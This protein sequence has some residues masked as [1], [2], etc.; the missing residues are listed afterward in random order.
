MSEENTPQL[1]EY[2]ARAMRLALGEI[3]KAH[4]AMDE[5][6]LSGRPEDMGEETWRT[7]HRELSRHQSEALTASAA[8][9]DQWDALTNKQAADATVLPESVLRPTPPSHSSPEELVRALEDYMSA[10][11]QM[12]AAM[13]DGVNVHGAL[14]NLIG[15]EDNARAALSNYRKC[16]SC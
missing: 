3:V 8:A 6:L 5:F 13:K 15:A 2:V 1:S 9:I 4:I 16:A 10:V 11:N 12:N 7:K 14:S